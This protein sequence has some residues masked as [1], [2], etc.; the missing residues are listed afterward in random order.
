MTV[1]SQ[2]A[3]AQRL[4]EQ[5]WC[6]L[7]PFKCKHRQ[8]ATMAA[9]TVSSQECFCLCLSSVCLAVR[10]I[11][12]SYVPW[13]EPPTRRASFHSPFCTQL[14]CHLLWEAVLLASPCP[15]SI[16]SNVHS[17]LPAPGPRWTYCSF[18]SITLVWF[19]YLYFFR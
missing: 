16:W 10:I 11:S 15:S 3:S 12:L 19:I 4:A 13:R 9:W 7:W 17:F 8:E 1:V 2:V 6:G 14:G 18:T 5:W